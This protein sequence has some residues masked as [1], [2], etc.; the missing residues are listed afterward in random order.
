MFITITQLQTAVSSILQ[1][2][3]GFSVGVGA[4]AYW[5]TLLNTA[6]TRSYWEIVQRLI[7]RGYSKGI[8]DQWD[9]GAEYQQDLGVWVSLVMVAS[10]TKEKITFGSLMVGLDRRGELSG[11]KG[12]DGQWIIDPVM[13]TIGGVLQQPDTDV[14][15][16]TT[17][18]IQGGGALG[19]PWETPVANANPGWWPQDT[20][21]D[22]PAGAGFEGWPGI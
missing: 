5:N 12:T 11:R 2:G 6:L 9:R 10:Q 14:S 15:Q 21:F 7:Q 18:Q 20:N 3:A 8:I 4:D 19:Y 16:V 1:K 17:G 13:V 22:I